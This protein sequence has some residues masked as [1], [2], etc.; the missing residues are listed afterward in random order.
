[1][2]VVRGGLAGRGSHAS[3]S[4][5]LRMYRTTRAGARGPQLADARDHCLFG[6]GSGLSIV[7][8]QVRRGGQVPRWRAAPRRSAG[9]AQLADQ[10]R[11]LVD[12]Q[13]AV[14][15]LDVVDRPIPIA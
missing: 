14:D 15:L 13:L 6:H 3:C 8:P 4:A 10:L 12:A 2:N 1:M 7:R 5:E 9:G 11:A